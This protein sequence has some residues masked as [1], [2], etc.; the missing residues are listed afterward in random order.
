MSIHFS[1]FGLRNGAGPTEALSLPPP[2]AS[3][4]RAESKVS[5]R[6]ISSATSSL[7]VL[8]MKLDLVLLGTRLRSLLVMD[9]RPPP[10]SVSASDLRLLGKA[11]LDFPTST[12]SVVCLL[13]FDG[14]TRGS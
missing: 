1:N 11:W 2:R 10:F 12:F 7:M 5:L 14:L 9:F 4:P 8:E 6:L 13:R 3:L